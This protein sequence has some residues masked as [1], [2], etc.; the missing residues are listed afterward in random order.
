[1]DL[2]NKSEEFLSVS[3]TGRVPVGARMATP[4]TSQG[5]QPAP[6]RGLRVPKASARRPETA[7]LHPHLDG[8][9][10]R[11]HLPGCV[12]GKRGRERGFSE[13]QI[14]EALESLKRALAALE[15]RSRGPAQ[16]VPSARI[17]ARRHRPRG[18]LRQT[19]PARGGRRGR[20]RRLSERHSLNGEDRS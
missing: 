12:R 18:Q 14:A 4:S 16:H 9:G 17:L 1:M 6:R 8:F 5:R 3:P 11:Q 7:G 13:T 2:E 15:E 19:T 20:P 10:R